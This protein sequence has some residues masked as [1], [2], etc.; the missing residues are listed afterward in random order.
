M[1]RFSMVVMAL[2]LLSF[3]LA[4]LACIKPK[5]NPLNPTFKDLH[6]T[7]P[8]AGLHV[9][10]HHDL[11]GDPYATITPTPTVTNTPTET[12]TVTNTPV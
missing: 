6:E 2:L 8:A 4:P 3:L 9:D 7:F 5:D 1:R 11:H 12:P 10:L